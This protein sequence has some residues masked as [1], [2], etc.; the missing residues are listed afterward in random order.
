MLI[1]G[2]WKMHGVRR[3][4]AEVVAIEHYV[5]QGCSASVALCVPAT[6]IAAARGSVE[7]VLIG[8][9]DCHQ[10]QGGAFTGQLSAA[11]LADAGAQVVVIG[12][13]ECRAAGDDD[14]RVGAKMASAVGAGLAPILCVGETAAEHAAG[15]TAAVVVDQARAAL[16]AAIVA[17]LA[18]AYEPVWAIGSGRVPQEC[19][20]AAVIAALRDCLVDRYGAAG[21]GVPILYGGSVTA[22]NA[23]ALLG[24]DDIGGVLVGGASLTA[25]SF[26]PILAAAA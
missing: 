10:A 22:G 14:A 21:S 1:V 19:D 3:R 8:A 25:N 7:A 16:P 17:G 13:S 18:L 6:L 23:A 12:H 26:V 11:M 20:I 15:R 4:L 2:N 9:Q 5:R 24:I